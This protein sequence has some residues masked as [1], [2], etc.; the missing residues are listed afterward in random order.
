MRQLRSIRVF[1]AII[2]FV[3]AAAYLLIGPQ[4]HPMAV[5]SV[6][7]QIIPSL[8]AV[9]LGVTAL[10]LILTFVF[11][12]IYCSTVCPVGTLQDFFIPLRKKFRRLN[13]PFRYKPAK[14]WRIH[15]L[16]VYLVCLI[17]PVTVIPALI[18]PWR[19]MQNISLS[20][21]SE[22][23]AFW[24]ELG[25]GAGVGI[26]AGAVSFIAL[27]VAAVVS[28]RDFCNTVC[29]LGTAMSLFNDHTVFHIE[30]DPDRCTNCMA[31][32]YE[33]KASCVKVVGRYVDN[34]RCVRCFDCLAACPENAIRYQI[35]RNIR[36]ASPLM[37][38]VKKAGDLN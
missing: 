18:E 19:I 1:L 17:V 26:A 15:V 12:R 7:S 11:G 38:K 31:C 29:P 34:S 8:L 4:V 22:A 5:I 25:V 21:N 32:E 33:C 24:A 9:T 35:N 13:R 6:K 37:K 27:A 28:G 23:T 16:I 14:K 20:V 2:F 10:W 36:P 30:I 3:A